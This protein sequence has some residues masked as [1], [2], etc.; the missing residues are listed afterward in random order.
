MLHRFSA[1]IFA[2]INVLYLQRFLN[3]PPCL[4]AL[5]QKILPQR[6]GEVMICVGKNCY[7]SVIS[8]AKP[9]KFIVFAF[10]Y[11]SLSCALLHDDFYMNSY[12]VGGDEALNASSLQF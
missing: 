8:I 6:S 7:I 2:I 5:I 9:K 10:T 12:S 3:L 1:L 4:N 11:V